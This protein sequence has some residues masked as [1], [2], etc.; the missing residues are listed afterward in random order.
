[1]FKSDTILFVVYGVGM[2]TCL[3]RGGVD[4]ELT[5][6]QKYEAVI[7]FRVQLIRWLGECPPESLDALLLTA[8]QVM[9]CKRELTDKELITLY[10]QNLEEVE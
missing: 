3:S 5:V 10:N 6:E 4:L 2:N 9:N 1:M 8:R 7:E